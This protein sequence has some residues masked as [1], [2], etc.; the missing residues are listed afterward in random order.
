[1]TIKTQCKACNEM[2]EFPNSKKQF[3]P[4]PSCQKCLS[5]HYDDVK[6]DVRNWLILT[7][8]VS[9]PFYKYW[10]VCLAISLILGYVL[11]A[12]GIL[13]NYRT[14]VISDNF[15]KKSAEKTQKSENSK[16]IGSRSS[17]LDTY[18]RR[19]DG[20]KKAPTRDATTFVFR[21]IS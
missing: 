15:C 1:M 12:R 6:I 2:I 9:V 14:S 8:L 13:I 3:R 11:L 17:E 7:V 16:L 18:L 10:Y 21:V 20:N 5:L 4:C 19:N